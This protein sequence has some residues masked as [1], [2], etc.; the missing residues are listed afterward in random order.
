MKKFLFSGVFLLLVMATWAKPNIKSNT[1]YRIVCQEMLSGCVVDGASFG[2]ATPLYYSITPTS[3]ASSYWYI[4]EISDGKYTIQNASTHQYVTYDGERIE[5]TKR[6]VRMDGELYGDS[7]TWTITHHGENTYAIRSVLKNS[8]I[9]DVRRDSYMVGTY[10]NI[11]VNTNQQFLFQTADG[12]RVNEITVP[13]AGETGINVDSWLVADMN[14]VENWDNMGFWVNLDGN[15][16]HGSATV[17]APFIEKWRNTR[18][19]GLLD[20]HLLQTLEN[21]PNGSYTVTADFISTRQNG[22]ARPDGVNFVFNNKQVTTITN[23]GVPEHYSLTTDVTDGRITTGV[24]VKDTNCNWVAIDN[25]H[26][27]FNGTPEELVAGE[28]AKVMSELQDYFDALT[29]GRK[30]DS[31]AAIYPDCE[32]LFAALET[33]R[34]SAESMPKIS[35]IERA[36]GDLIIGKHGMAYDERNAIYLASIP[37]KN[38]GTNYEATVT[39]TP[40]AGYGNLSINGTEVPSGSSYTFDNVAAEGTYTLSITNAG[41]TTTEAR[42]TFTSLPIVQIYGKFGNSYTNGYFR[43]YEPD[44]QEPE[45]LFMKAKWRGG[46]TNSPNKHKRNYRVKFLDENGKKKDRKF[47]GLRND[48][49]WILEACQVDMSRVRNRVLTD[50]W[51]DFATKPYYFDQEPKAL[52]GTRGNFVEVLLNGKYVGIYSMTEVMD[53][54]QMKLKKY[55]EDTDTEHG[56]LYKSSDW[57]YSV[58]MGHDYN[59]NVY[60]GRSPIPYNNNSETWD[61]YEIKYPDFDDYNKADWEPL[62][63]AVNFVATS[64]DDDFRNN[65]STYFDY[66][67]VKDYYIFMETLLSADNHGKNMYFGVYDRQVSPKITFGVWD[68]DATVGQRWSTDYYHDMNLMSPERDYAEFITNYEHGDYNVFRRLRKTNAN[69][70]NEEIRLRYAELRKSYLGTESILNRFRTYIDEF[71]L[72][73]AAARESRRWSYDSDISG[74]K[75]DFDDEVQYIS[76]WVTRRMNYL[77]R[78][79]FRIGELSGI[80]NIQNVRGYRIDVKGKTIVITSDKPV[81]VN[82]YGLDGTL[83]H[84]VKANVGQTFVSSL[85][86][87]IYLIGNQKVVLK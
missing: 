70:F 54:K 50:L 19:G 28:R 85:P 74:L 47:F 36:L 4:N 10:D 31:I 40:K 22:S 1:R 45:L 7:S 27:Y 79:R 35:P 42:L 80:H 24:K 38:F 86:A 77:D 34:R 17:Q 26:I 55:D 46:I 39:Y 25:L 21:L 12:T 60:P 71:K 83:M 84:R 43:I 76:N 16:A 68:L 63:N 52:S 18:E 64:S 9:W 75:L 57:S 37:L 11:G 48:N 33:F 62:W 3:D 8:E 29:I 15:Y 73:G 72:S 51:N 87:G 66:P 14:S 6:Y 13:T 82:V 53:R 58:F 81:V 41:G 65:F 61:N 2:Q 23:D 32:S 20:S 69:N 49:N 59:S 30:I 67:V 5:A 56:L 78:T 44:K